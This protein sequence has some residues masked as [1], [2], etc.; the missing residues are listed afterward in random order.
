MGRTPPPLIHVDKPTLDTDGRTLGLLGSPPNRVKANLIDQTVKWSADLRYGVVHAS[1][2]LSWPLVVQTLFGGSWP[3]GLSLGQGLKAWIM[4][5]IERRMADPDAEKVLSYQEYRSEAPE[6]YSY[7]MEA[8]ALLSGV[9]RGMLFDDPGTGKTLSAILGT[10]RMR[11]RFPHLRDQAV[12]VICPPSVVDQ[13]IE[14]WEQWTHL[15]A[16]AWRGPAK[17]RRDLLGSA[18]VYVAGYPAIR[19][20]TDVLTDEQYR[21]MRGG[22]SRFGPLLEMGAGTLILDEVQMIK[23]PNA[24]QSLAA[25]RLAVRSE[26]LI[27]LS[28][29]PIT[30]NIG[31]IWPA[32]N[33]L[34]PIAWPSKE[35]TVKRYLV[36]DNNSGYAEKIHG[37]MPEREPEFRACLVG[38]TRRVSKQDAL[39]FLPPKVYTVRT[40]DIPTEY[41]EA[42]DSMERDMIALLPNGDELTTMDA[43]AVISR[44][45]QL[46][47]AAATVTYTTTM[48]LDKKTGEMVE[49]VHTKVTLTEPS[50]KIDDLVE[51]VGERVGQQGLVFTPS[52]Q[53]IRLAARR[54]EIEGY[55][56]GMIIGGQKPEERDAVRKAF[57]AGELDIIC[58]TTESGGT[59][60]TLTKASYVAFL[61]RPW[62]YGTSTQAE[63]RA[64]RMG[65]EM[66]ESIEIIDIVARGTIDTRIRSVIKQKSEAL[67]EL[68]QDPRVMEQC[69]GDGWRE[70]HHDEKGEADA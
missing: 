64:H 15:S 63:D 28:G 65:S 25:R 7:Q 14:A 18:D 21:Q 6:P 16:I 70:T 42:Y 22:R 51:A 57:Q 23:N 67:A 52:A 10:L 27:G 36:T 20:D 44:L 17:R 41:K 38:Q 39:P 12:L 2:P 49:K 1:A 24:V 68:L 50:W 4:D 56:V 31:D 19:K 11:Q 3:Q 37:L 32:L 60:L 5:E 55:R 13:W 58:A 47:C 53:L 69:L 35:R 48:V 43:L 62:S 34:D 45:L 8:A 9:G 46:S 26:V 33:A 59:G 30:H 61:Q 66:H 54:L 29:T 40:V